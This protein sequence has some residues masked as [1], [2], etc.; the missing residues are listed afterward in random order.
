[1]D[2]MDILEKADN[3]Y[4]E[5]GE[6]EAFDPV[7]ELLNSTGFSLYGVYISESI[8][9]EWSDN[10]LADELLEDGD[11]CD[12]TFETSSRKRWWDI[13]VM[14]GEDNEYIFEHLDLGSGRK[15]TLRCEDGAAL[16]EWE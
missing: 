7:F 16:V 5:V 6:G 10:L 9:D 12:I 2:L 13:M 14:D 15:V 1:M 11:S 4:E 8:D 3:I